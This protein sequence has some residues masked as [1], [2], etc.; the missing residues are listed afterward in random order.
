MTG[1]LLTIFSLVLLTAS[2]ASAA[3]FQ[4]DLSQSGAVEP[5][6]IDWNTG[7]KVDNANVS[8]QFLKQA[9]FDDDF[10]IDFI[11]IDS[12]NRATVDQTIPLHDVLGDAF[13]ESNPFDMVIKGLAP[14]I[15]VF[16]GWHHD[17]KED[18]PND[19]GTLN[20]TVKDADGTRVVADH[21]Q[22]SW[23]PKPAF[24]CASSF[25]FR[26][27]G[28]NNVTITF[29]DNNDGNNNEAYLNGFAIEVAVVPSQASKP[30]PD[31][32]AVDVPRDVVLRWTPADTAPATNGHR[33][34]FSNVEADVKNGAATAN[35]G[36]VSLPEFDVM[37]LPVRLVYETTY[38]WRIDEASTTGWSAGP[39]WHFTTEPFAYRIPSS[40]ITATASSRHNDSMTPNKTINGAGLD[41]SDGHSTAEADMWMSSNAGPQPSWIQYEFDEVYSLKEMWVWNFNQT[42][43]PLVGFGIKEASIQYSADGVTWATLAERTQIARAP[44]TAGYAH[45][46]TLDFGGVAARYVRITA[47]SSWGGG[48][49][50]GLSE[51]HFYYVPMSVREPQPASAAA[52][53]GPEV[54][55][56]WRAGREAAKHDVYLGLDEGAVLGGTVPTASVT[57][58]SY[59]AGTLQLA[60]TYYW[61]VDEVNA[62]ETPAEWVGPVWSFLTP[63]FLPVDDFETYTNESPNRVFQTWIDGAGF[64]S[65]KFFPDGNPGNGSGSLVGYDPLAGKIMETVIIHGGAQSMP[66]AYD[67]TSGATRSEAERTFV[68]PQDWTQAGIKALTLHFRGAAE[69]TP[70]SLY[71]K[72]N[73]TKIAYDGAQTDISSLRWVEW[74]IDLASIGGN[75]R[76]VNKLTIGVENGGSGTLYI[77]DIRLYPSRCVAALRQPQGDLN[78]D[79]TVDYLDVQIMARDWLAGD[80]TLATAPTASAKTG[81]LAC[82][83]LDGNVSD[84]S[85]SNLNGT[86]KG[87]PVYEAGVVGQA[88]MF[89]GIDDYVD[90][91]NNVKFDTITENITVA[92]WIRVDV[93]DKTY[94]AIV[95]KGDSSWRIARNGESNGI[96]WRCN[97]PPQTLRINGNVNVNDAQ[98]HHVA[99]TYDGAMARLYIDGIPDG[100]MAATGAISKNT[101]SVYIGGNAEQTARMWKGSIDDVRIYNRALTDAEVR[102][103]ADST[104]GDGKLYLPVRSA[105]ELYEKE[106]ANSRS[107]NMRDFAELAG[108]WLSMQ[109]WP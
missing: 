61:R 44:G 7:S 102:L 109:L 89:D 14:G 17:P 80:A 68:V 71:V 86:A 28:T 4:V 9:E 92:A 5:G 34:Y 46:T 106:P 67:N 21:L 50:Y 1:K 6:W 77:D 2:F 65:D 74:N 53:V 72:I 100:S 40:A 94:Q 43:E 11:K 47:I 10:T 56:K 69:N 58:S 84:T 59:D 51:V 23:G 87:N 39:V 97:G 42:L 79:C 95:T 38:Y 8:K 3:P 90:C 66:L 105:A 18:V 57:T 12:R 88:M 76:S 31:Q 103:L 30:Q 73:S 20:I 81:L 13:K 78:G 54:V 33:V 37:S 99:G 25:T 91:T 36:T 93:F 29:G 70:G 62:A 104:P 64:S 32:G 96:Q 108:Q 27:D 82:Y 55:L 15:Y 85:G 63:E 60:S 19:D 26:S 41:A 75:L 48:S 16:K 35:R 49:Q 22:Q 101:A 45:N 24:V 52:G 83:T 107:V 98:W